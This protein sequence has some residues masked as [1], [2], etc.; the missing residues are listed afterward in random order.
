M[1]NTDYVPPYQMFPSEFLS[2]GDIYKIFAENFL[3]IGRMISGS[4]SG[5]RD[6]YPNNKVVFNANI[7]TKSKGKVWHGDLDITLDYDKL[8][9]VANILKEDLYIL[10][11]MDARFENENAGFE[12]WEKKAVEKIK[13]HGNNN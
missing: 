13:Y 12:Y 10:Y 2:D 4:K 9:A 1:E 5:Y 6:R 3:M 7:V 8:Q 11:E